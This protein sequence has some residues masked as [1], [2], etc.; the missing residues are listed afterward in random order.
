[1][2]I[3]ILLKPW[4]RGMNVRDQFGRTLALC[5]LAFLSTPK[6][7]AFKGF[8]RADGCLVC[9]WKT[10]LPHRHL[11]TQRALI[12]YSASLFLPLSVSLARAR[13]LPGRVC[14]QL[15]LPRML[16]G[17]SSILWLHYQVHHRG[18]LDLMVHPNSG[19]TC[20]RGC[21]CYVLPLLPFLCLCL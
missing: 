12:R 4:Q 3:C 8:L 21:P 18:D 1:M 5:T 16:T 14:S 20:A 2:H 7:W 9:T 11:V 13:S 10:I 15:L 19:C 17:G 6:P